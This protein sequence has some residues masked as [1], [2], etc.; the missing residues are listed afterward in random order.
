MCRYSYQQILL[1]APV[2]S[3]VISCG[4]C[5]FISGR[6]RADFSHCSPS[7]ESGTSAGRAHA[8][9]GAAAIV[10]ITV[11]AV[12]VS[13]PAR[14]LSLNGGVGGA[15]GGSERQVV[16]VEQLKLSVMARAFAIAALVVVAADLSEVLSVEGEGE[17][18]EG[19]ER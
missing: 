11:L 18:V 9:T 16:G 17:V 19:S 6:P 1:F 14:P 12:T 5:R 2:A 10:M 15:A 8:F 3:H 13:S 7:S 4:I